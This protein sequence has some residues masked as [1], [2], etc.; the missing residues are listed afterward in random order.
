M[1]SK[2]KQHNARVRATILAASVAALPTSALAYSAGDT[3]DL[4]LPAQIFGSAYGNI[5]HVQAGE[6]NG[7]ARLWL[8]RA[9]MQLNMH[10]AGF[11]TSVVRSVANNTNHAGYGEPT[12]TTTTNALYWSY[13]NNTS[14]VNLHP[15]GFV[16]SEAYGAG[17]SQQ[18]GPA[19]TGGGA[20]P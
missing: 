6:T 10:P 7:Q 20:L 9:D 2:M 17:G 19:A 13:Q 15:A 11:S 3:F 16:R 8:G 4:K 18:V 1:E 5:G 12:G 14:V